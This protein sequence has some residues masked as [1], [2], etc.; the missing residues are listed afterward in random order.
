MGPRG[1]GKREEYLCQAQ[2]KEVGL[3]E[4][5]CGRACCSDSWQD[6]KPGLL[7]AAEAPS[8]CPTSTRLLLKHCQVPTR[9]GRGSITAATQLCLPAYTA[10]FPSPA[11]SIEQLS[12]PIL[13]CPTRSE[14]L[15]C[16]S[17]CPPVPIHQTPT[18]VLFALL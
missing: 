17:Q 8:V 12:E 7:A 13:V 4:G 9:V 10:S 15:K 2:C 16:S 11:N 14:S 5:H 1:A 18:P 3:N 6:L